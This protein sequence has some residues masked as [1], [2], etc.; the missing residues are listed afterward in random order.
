MVVQ[1]IP[2][3]SVSFRKLVDE[4]ISDCIYYNI[5][6]NNNNSALLHI[7]TGLKKVM[8]NIAKRRWSV[9]NEDDTN[10]SD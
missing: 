3:N 4:G 9:S 2:E 8:I 7:I 10:V 1:S 5:M 6:Y